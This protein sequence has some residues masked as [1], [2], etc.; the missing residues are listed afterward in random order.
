[1]VD[2]QPD[3]TAPTFH[4]CPPDITIHTVGGNEVPAFWPI[5]TATDNCETPLIVGSNYDCGHLFPPGDHTVVYTATDLSGN[6]TTCTFT[7]HVIS[8]PER[9]RNPMANTF[10]ANMKSL[11]RASMDQVETVLKEKAMDELEI[12]LL[13]NPFADQLDLASSAAPTSAMAV[14]VYD[15]TGRLVVAS[16]WEAGQAMYRVQTADWKPGVYIIKVVNAP[17]SLQKAYMGVKL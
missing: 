16:V 10:I 7:V 9:G 2:V 17:A 6:V 3:L 12:A 5:P 4:F 14:Q 13:P 8:N 15:L 11:A 1:M